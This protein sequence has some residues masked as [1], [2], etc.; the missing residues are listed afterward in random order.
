MKKR[1]RNPFFS[2]ISP[3]PC[4]SQ[5]L[6]IG[7]MS[8]QG[9]SKNR[10][11]LAAKMF[12]GH[13]T[14]IIYFHSFNPPCFS[15]LSPGVVSLQD[16]GKTFGVSS[17]IRIPVERKDDG[18]ALS[19]EAFHPALNGQKRIRHYRLDVY[20]KSLLFFCVCVYASK[21]FLSIFQTN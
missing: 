3:S 6:N 1:K 4:S 13:L 8:Q 18:A 16:N 7:V 11:I 15:R 10:H 17:T 9:E 5:S 19:C 2:S 14:C 21:Q 20:C 12:L